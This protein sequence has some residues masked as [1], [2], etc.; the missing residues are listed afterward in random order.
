MIKMIKKFFSNSGK[1]VSW[2]RWSNLRRMKKRY[3]VIIIVVFSIIGFNVWGSFA[4]QQQWQANAVVSEVVRQDLVKELIRSGKVELQGVFQVTPKISGVIKQL[5]VTNG[6]KV[7]ANEILFQIKS[8][9]SAAE[10]A[11]AY[12][13]F[14]GAK[15]TYQDAKNTIGHTEWI[16]FEQQRDALVQAENKL[17]KFHEQYPDH[18]KVNNTK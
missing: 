9:A 13:S 16:A 7:K 6:Q 14:L 4:S 12:A 8:D 5:K 10:R 2:L 11:N 15:N 1:I 18:L 17:K 3:W